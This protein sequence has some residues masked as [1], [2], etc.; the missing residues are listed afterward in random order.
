MGKNGRQGFTLMELVVVLVVLVGLAGIVVA[1]LPSMVQR[2]HG[3]AG[4]ANINEIAKW[5]QSYEAIYF[6]YPDRWDAILTA[7]GAEPELASG[8][9]YFELGTHMVAL[10]LDAAAGHVS[11]LTN[12]GITT[13]YHS[14]DSPEHPTFDPYLYAMGVP[15]PTAVADTVNVV[16]LTEAGKQHLALNL[17]ITNQ[18]VVLG[19]GARSSMLGKGIVEVPTHF[20]EHANEDPSRVY[21]RFGVVFQVQSSTGA[22]SRARP[23]RVV[24][25]HDG[26]VSTGSSHMQEYFNAASNEN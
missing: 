4:A 18:Y 26:E 5:V 1:M 7:G 16:G 14:T 3:A 10:P 13:L 22:L 17:G 8:D 12:A 20:P 21:S 15:T 19:L 24:A 9:E 23:V 2:T 6:Q 11:A 25:F